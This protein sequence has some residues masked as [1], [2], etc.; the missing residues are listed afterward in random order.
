MFSTFLTTEWIRSSALVVAVLVL[1]PTV[2][3]GQASE[4]DSPTDSNPPA[5]SSESDPG[6]DRVAMKSFRKPPMDP[7]KIASVFQAQAVMPEDVPTVIPGFGEDQSDPGEQTEGSGEEQEV[8]IKIAELISQLGAPEFAVRE[9]ATAGL[10]KLADDALPALRTA[11]IEH[12][13]LEVRLRAEDVATGIVNSAVAGRIDSFL[14]G[15]PGSFEGWEVFQ[16]VLGDGPRL[17]EVFVEMMLRHEDLVQALEVS[18]EARMAALEKVIARVQRRQLIESQLPSAPD[19]IAML[20]CFN[21][22][23]LKLSNIHEEALLRMLRMSVTAEVLRDD[24][25]AE[26]FRVLLAGW[27]PRCNQASRPEVLWMS[28]QRDLERT[29]PFAEKIVQQPESG[30]DEVAFSLQ[31]I[32]RFGDEN[33]VDM[34]RGLLGDERP[35]TDFEFIGD[36]PIQAQVRDLA[37]ATIMILKRKPLDEI[38]L[39]PNSL[40][41]KTGFVARD[42]GFPANDPEPRRKMLEALDE[43]LESD[44]EP[45]VDA[46]SETESN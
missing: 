32:S 45:A 1:S 6:T 13:D 41:P 24:Q 36:S 21:D 14:E 31:L 39:N 7:E 35:V 9:Q 17:R 44:D 23:E 16:R 34:V 25:L 18:T 28:L 15:E 30:I 19:V 40:H 4:A 33:N 20:L 3:C 27:I 8:Q 37:A 42:L 46:P 11:A 26:P 38:G 29:L 43:L 5:E 10:R 12:D 2:A 22:P